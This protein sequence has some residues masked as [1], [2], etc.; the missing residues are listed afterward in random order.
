MP[1]TNTARSAVAKGPFHRSSRSE[2]LTYP[3]LSSLFRTNFLYG[4]PRNGSP[5]HALILESTAEAEIFA[6]SITEAPVRSDLYYSQLVPA[7]PPRFF[8]VAALLAAAV[9]I[10]LGYRFLLLFVTLYST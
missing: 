3:H 6:E 4:A 8:T 10:F 2:E 7:R 1:P 9:A 5:R